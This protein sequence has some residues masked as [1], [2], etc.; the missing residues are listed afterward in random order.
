MLL[1]VKSR[2]GFQFGLDSASWALGLFF[3]TLVRY[4][5]HVGRIAI[6]GLLAFVGLAIGL[7]LALGFFLALYRGRYRFGSFDEVAALA[8]TVG[9]VTCTLFLVDLRLTAHSIPLSS[10][11]GGGLAALALMGGT[12]YMWRLYLEHTRRPSVEGSTRLVVFGAGDAGSQVITAMQRDPQ[13]PYVP[14][15]LLD[16]DPAKQR[17]RITG[18]R[19]VGTRTSIASVAER[20]EADGLLIAIP[21]ASGKL[22]GDLTDL[23]SRANLKVNVLPSVAELLGAGVSVGDIRPV[24]EADLL[25]RHVID[26]DIA[27]IAGYLTGKR[28]LVTGAGGS[29][30]SEL[31]RQINRFAPDAL[32]MLDRDESALLDVQLSI[33]GHGRLDSEDL[34][35]ADIRHSESIRRVFENHRPDVVFHAAALKHVPLL[36]RHP[37]E[38]IRTNVFGTLTLLEA[39]A[40]HHVERFVNISTDKAADPANVLGYSKRICERLTAHFAQ[41]NGGVFLSVRFGNVLGSRGSMLETFKRQIEAEGPVTVTHPEVTRFFMTIEEAVELVI[42]AAA[43][44]RDGEVLVLDMGVPVRIADVARRLVAQANRPVRIEY[45]GLRLGEK[46]HEMLFA[47]DEEDRRPVHELISHVHVPPLEPNEVGELDQCASRESLSEHLLMLC[48]VRAGEPYGQ[49]TQAR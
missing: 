36:E 25:G 33:D 27:S 22:I 6:G 28:V 5:L 31:C 9:L 15:A 34:V 18:V 37:E 44:G 8:P 39:C 24:T 35:L 40:E 13:S 32:I 46:L 48:S 20:F 19:V 16:D 45:T 23:A 42:Q 49:R 14:V 7:Q 10:T 47:A 29:I 12:R 21:T 2:N 1:L 26:T 38:A 41:R 30:G 43:I 4:D 3:G 11:L 17:L